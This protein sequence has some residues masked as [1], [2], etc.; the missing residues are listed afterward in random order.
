MIANKERLGQHGFYG[1]PN[2]AGWDNIMRD[3]IESPG[4]LHEN[5]SPICALVDVVACGRQRPVSR[6]R[7]TET[8]W[9]L[10]YSIFH[11]YYVLMQ[12]LIIIQTGTIDSVCY[13][14]SNQ[15]DDHIIKTLSA[16]PL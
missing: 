14:N 10:Y 15:W 9:L 1:F 16:Q 8:H 5:Y 3:T 2:M 11:S 6:E 7:E 13:Q 4:V 12:Q